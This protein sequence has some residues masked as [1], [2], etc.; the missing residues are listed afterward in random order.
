GFELVDKLADIHAIDWLGVGLAD[1]ARKPEEFL[2]R[3]LRRMQ[4]LYDAVRHRE[5]AEI[6]EVGAW[7]HANA[8]AQ[9]D[10]TLTHGDYK[11]DNVILCAEAPAHIA[12]V[13]DWE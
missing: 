9:R 12:A 8:P 4:E 1:L 5:V 11:L 6:E 10:V 13:V 2:A 7:L 3:N